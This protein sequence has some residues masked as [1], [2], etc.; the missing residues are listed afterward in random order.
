[1]H[2]ALMTSRTWLVI[3]FLG[4]ASVC[5]AAYDLAHTTPANRFITP[6]GKVSYTVTFADNGQAPAVPP[7]IQFIGI[8][9]SQDTPQGRVAVATPIIADLNNP[10]VVV[11]PDL[12]LNALISFKN[13]FFP[14]VDAAP[15]SA[16]LKAA[17]KQAWLDSAY[18]IYNEQP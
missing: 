8:P 17:I 9:L 13:D 4:S 16:G 12:V 18:T 5:G 1:M 3:A 7:V 14:K 10:Q 2:W 6:S 11:Q 15:L